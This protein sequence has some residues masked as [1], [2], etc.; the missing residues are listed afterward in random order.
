[1]EISKDHVLLFVSCQPHVSASYVMQ[2]IKGKTSRKLLQQFSHLNKQCW[3]RNLCAC[4]FFVG[5]SRVVAGEAIIEYIRT[6]DAAT[7][8]GSALRMNDRSGL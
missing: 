6:Q 8:G 1:V 2:R 3:G 7:K 5:S 4:G